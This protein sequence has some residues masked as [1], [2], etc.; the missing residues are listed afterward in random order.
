MVTRSDIGFDAA[1]GTHMGGWLFLP[2][3][4]GPHPTISMAHGYAAIKEQGLAPFAEAFAKAGYAVMVHDHRNFGASGGEPRGDIDPWRQIADWRR[5]ISIL[6]ARPEVDA[7]RL[8][9]WGSSYAGGHAI[10]LGATDRRLRAIVSQ[11][12]T[13]S[14]FEQSRRRTSPDDTAAAA[15]AFADDERAQS[16]G[17]PPVTLKVVTDDPADKAAYRSREAFDFYMKLAKGTD[18]QNLVTLQSGYRS[19]MYEPGAWVARVSPTPLM[20]IVGRH[21]TLTLT[22]VGLVA[23][24]QALEPKRLVLIEGGHFTP[25]VDRFD[26]ASKAAIDWFDQHLA[27]RQ[28]N[29]ERTK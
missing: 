23:Y 24:E 1:D 2:D 9:V 11:V 10:V 6:E 7:S 22:D 12:P 25:Y 20:M 5:A 27:S 13:I 14:G 17:E 21:D 15:E 8:G 18:W 26:E 28:S 3:G 29:T 4:E 19:Q 16:R